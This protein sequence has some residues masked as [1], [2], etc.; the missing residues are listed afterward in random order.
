MGRGDRPPD[1]QSPQASPARWRRWQKQVDKWRAFLKVTAHFTPYLRGRKGQL[2]L[3]LILA[4]SVML[5]RL[6]TPW[7]LKLVIDNVILGRSLPSMLSF[8]WL[9]TDS[10]PLVLLYV[11]VAA[12]LAIAFG[13]GLFY[14]HQKIVMSRLGINI[15]ADLRRDL[16][17]HIQYLSLSFHDRRRTGDLIVRLTSDIRIVRQAFV[18]LPLQLVESVL[19]VSGMAVVMLFM[20]WQLT[21]LAFALVPVLAIM[22]RHYHRPMKQAVRKQRK[23]EGQLASTASETLGA[24]RVVQGFRRERERTVF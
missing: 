6:L 20:D 4:T 13:R 17:T 1:G 24:I 3:G 7:P 22:V 23:R 10:N 14:Y 8:D 5:M 11:L 21:L 9:Q 18:S 16:Y 19:L 2:C 15:V 12:I